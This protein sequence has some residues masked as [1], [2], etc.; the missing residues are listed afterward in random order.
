VSQVAL[1]GPPVVE[2]AVLGG[3]VLWLAGAAAVVVDEGAALVAAAVVDDEGAAVVD[4]VF[5]VAWRLAA[6]GDD[7]PHA[8]VTRATATA[9]TTGRPVRLGQRRSPPGPVTARTEPCSTTPTP[10][11]SG[12]PAAPSPLQSPYSIN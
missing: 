12:A 6:V 9:A 1:S 7:E 4:V 5:V 2:Q 11:G 8:E 10:F 3:V